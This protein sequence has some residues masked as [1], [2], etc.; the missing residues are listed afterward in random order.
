M[1]T[2]TAAMPPPITKP[3]TTDA[4]LL[5]SLKRPRNS[6]LPKPSSPTAH[7]V[8]NSGFPKPAPV[9]NKRPAYTNS[10]SVPRTANR[11]VLHVG[12]TPGSLASRVLIVGD[13]G[14]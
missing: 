6:T 4:N 10:N 5:T 11:S 13:S 2:T 1:S 12:L 9:H 14:E 8:L 7:A 3:T